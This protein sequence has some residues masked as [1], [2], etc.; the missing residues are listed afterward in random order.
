MGDAAG[1]GGY[2]IA[3]HATAI[4]ANPATLTGS[5]GVFGGKFST[6]GLWDDLGIHWGAVQQGRNADIWSALVPYSDT[7]R[8][9]LDAAIDDIYARFVARVA[10]GRGLEPSSVE[11]IAE[12]RVWTGAQ[13]VSL[14]LV[15]TLGGLHAAMATIRS[16]LFLADDAAI[17][18]VPLPRQPS[19][20][21]ALM[22]LLHG[23]PVI[24][25]HVELPAA[26]R[27]V[28]DQLGPLLAGSSYPALTMPPMAIAR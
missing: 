9:R 12:G 21:E 3:T 26:L 15:D 6:A 14:G 20:L 2:W 23:D 28:A 18:L 17:E 24:G 10:D 8:E 22:S 27:E 7:G 19:P 25:A 5:I 16:D 11:A 1:S 4:V 13:A